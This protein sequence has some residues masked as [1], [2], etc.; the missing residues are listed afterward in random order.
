MNQSPSQFPKGPRERLLLHSA[1][2]WRPEQELGRTCNAHHVVAL[3]VLVHRV[4][5]WLR[6]FTTMNSMTITEVQDQPCFAKV[7]PTRMGTNISS[8]YHGSQYSGGFSKTYI[9][10]L[11]WGA[12]ERVTTAW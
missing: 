8:V 2:A 12:K 9:S 11:R 3:V 4:G 6:I 10:K 1:A 5:N 7:M